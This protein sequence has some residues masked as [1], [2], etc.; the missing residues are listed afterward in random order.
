MAN[1]LQFGQGNIWSWLKNMANNGLA[2]LTN[3]GAP[4]SGG[5]GTGATKAGVGCLLIDTTNAKLYI[6]TGTKASPTWTVVGT[7]T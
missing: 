7:Q 1:S 3:A 2:I 4:T 6:N 5:S